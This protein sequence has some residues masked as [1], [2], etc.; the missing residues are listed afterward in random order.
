MSKE[1][2]RYSMIYNDIKN[3]IL[4]DVY[5][6][7]SLLPT[8]QVLSL[9]YDVNRS[10]LRKA[11]QMLADEGLIEKCPGKGTIVLSSVPVASQKKIL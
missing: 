3:D 2:F 7:G 11:M 6:V 10:T 4:N 1:K 8:E 5:K 9:K